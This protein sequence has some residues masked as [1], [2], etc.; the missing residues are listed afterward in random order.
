MR[1]IIATAIGILMAFVIGKGCAM[2]T[3]EMPEWQ[4]VMGLNQGGE[5]L[6]P[7]IFGVAIWAVIMAW[8]LSALDK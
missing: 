1:A 2:L 7:V 8:V 6:V 5:N 4:K 3:P